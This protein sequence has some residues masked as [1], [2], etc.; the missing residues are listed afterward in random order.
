MTEQ[1]NKNPNQYKNVLGL[2][3][4]A[5]I[6]AA[7]GYFYFTRGNDDAQPKT[8]TTQQASFEFQDIVAQTQH[9]PFHTPDSTCSIDSLAMDPCADFLIEPGKKGETY[10]QLQGTNGQVYRGVS[11]IKQGDNTL[12]Y[13]A[14][15]NPETQ[16]A[17]KLTKIILDEN[18]VY[19]GGK[20][21][22]LDGSSI[23]PDDIA[24]ITN[25]EDLKILTQMGIASN[26]YA[27]EFD[28]IEADFEEYEQTIFG[29]ANTQGQNGSYRLG[30]I[31]GLVHRNV[32]KPL[33]DAINY[34]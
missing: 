29:K 3:A 28:G 14:E 1:K 7:A 26:G 13:I 30:G 31:A 11:N 34:Q 19:I 9:L 27:K 23:L 20:R 5:I 6:A 32:I 25:N 2:G 4:L 10:F 8:P 21:I 24:Q 33:K 17:T 22:T 12:T 16:K 18:N 15:I